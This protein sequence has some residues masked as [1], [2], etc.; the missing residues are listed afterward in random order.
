MKISRITLALAA[1]IAPCI[2]GQQAAAEHLTD[3]KCQCP[4]C[5]KVCCP[6]KVTKKEKESCWEV[7]CK[8]VCIPPVRFPWMKCWPLSCGRI[9]VVNVLK[10]EETEVEK[11]E[12]KWKVVDSCPRH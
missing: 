4:E 11:C 9:R 1:A 3:R 10:K 8:E 2:G 7:E 6:E 5:T 12:V